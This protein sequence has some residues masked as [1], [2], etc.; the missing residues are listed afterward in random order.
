MKGAFDMS[1]FIAAEEARLGGPDPSRSPPAVA[2]VATVAGDDWRAGL[3]SLE[4]LPRPLCLSGAAWD[5]LRADARSFG[6]AWADQAFSLGWQITDAFGAGPAA[7]ER[8]YH[9][10][11]IAYLMNGRPVVDVQADHAI[12]DAGRGH[13]WTFRLPRQAGSLPLWIVFGRGSKWQL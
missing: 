1:R 6:S 13:C 5:R 2:T 11:G 8:Q 3:A 4:E 7:P 9:L 10:M 12:I